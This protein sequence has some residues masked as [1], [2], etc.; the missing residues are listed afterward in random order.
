MHVPVGA[1]NSKEGINGDNLQNPD[2]FSF[3][4]G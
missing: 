4:D 2:L 1:Q 3:K